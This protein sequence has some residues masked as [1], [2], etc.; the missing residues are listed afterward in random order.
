MLPGV[1]AEVTTNAA[2][3]SI[4]EYVMMS[5]KRQCRFRCIQGQY[6]TEKTRCKGSTIG[7]RRRFMARPRNGVRGLP[8]RRIRQA[9]DLHHRMAVPKRGGVGEISRSFASAYCHTMMPR[10]RRSSDGDRSLAEMKYMGADGSDGF[11]DVRQGCVK[12]SIQSPISKTGAR[13]YAEFT[14]C[15]SITRHDMP[16]TS[17]PQIFRLSDTVWW[18]EYHL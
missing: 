7:S 17:S 8:Q 16:K 4:A 10:D 1:T 5:S 9:E 11:Y 14:D 15:E 13:A 3:I 12:Q 2:R 6:H 18:H